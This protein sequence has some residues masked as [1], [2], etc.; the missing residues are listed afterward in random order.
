MEKVRI[1]MEMASKWTDATFMIILVI[2][3]II[4]YLAS[5]IYFLLQGQF[6][7]SVLPTILTVF[8]WNFV[9]HGG[10]GGVDTKKYIVFHDAALERTYA[11]RRYPM[12]ELYE[13]Y[14]DGKIDFNT[15]IEGGDCLEILINHR[16]EFVNYKITMR[17]IRWLLSQF[18]P[19]WLMKSGFGF[20]SS[21][22]K[23]KASTKKEIAEHYDRGND[24]FNA[25]MG[26]SMVYTSGVFHNLDQ[27]LEEAQFNKMQLICEKIQ[28]KKG[29]K[30][31][32][33]GC[34]WGT[35]A[36]HAAREFDAEA[37]GVTLSVEGKAWCD[38]KS[39]EEKTP[40][41]ILCM[42]YR[43]IPQDRKF[44][45]IASIEM[46]EHVGLQNFVDP[47]LAGVS[48][49]MKDDGIFLMQVAG[50]RQGS[51]WQDVAWG[52]FMSKYIFP[53]A[54]ASTPLNW[55]IKQLELAGFEVHSVETI[56]RHYSHTLHK[57]YDNWMT[58][59]EEITENPKYGDRL[60]RLWEFFLAWST[61]AAGQGSA[62]CYQIVAH[63]NKYDYPRDRWCD[64][65]YVSSKNL[66]GVGASLH[67]KP[68]KHKRN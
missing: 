54:D 6:L 47:Y 22:F 11:N 43:D 36:R 39:K 28:L 1:G 61:V 41:E 16:D 9:Y 33:I 27:T 13:D 65:D 59:R 15:E 66:V 44:D 8:L 10:D 26:P 56:G 62:T 49:L 24:F 5:T 20:G 52:L 46:A 55:Y 25:F 21:S 67:L 38:M 32:D 30:F 18:I 51:N 64:V 45:K 53:G 31:L 40:T 4:S 57:W 29:E 7:F 17:K 35:L 58:H 42:D 34:G 60:F 68:K 23:D 19:P 63:K 48:R 2:P 37:T 50:L 3:Y 14:I 12:C